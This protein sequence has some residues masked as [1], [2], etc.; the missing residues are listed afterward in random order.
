MSAKFVQGR[1][2]ALRQ[3]SGAWKA[4]LASAFPSSVSVIMSPVVME[5]Q[6]QRRLSLVSNPGGT[7]LISYSYSVP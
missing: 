5:F 4:G 1:V 6:G 2:H 3:S 7:C